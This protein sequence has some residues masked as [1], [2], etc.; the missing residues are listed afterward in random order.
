MLDQVLIETWLSHFQSSSALGQKEETCG[1]G[2]IKA[3]ELRCLQGLERRGWGVE[4][5]G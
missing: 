4:G 3:Q 1:S 5:V 2:D